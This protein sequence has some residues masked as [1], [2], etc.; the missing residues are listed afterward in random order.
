MIKGAYPHNMLMVGDRFQDIEAG[1]KNNIL[2]IGCNY[3]YHRLGELD[4]AD[5]RINNIKDLMTLL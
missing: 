1:K 5:Y 3:G 2:T 4:G